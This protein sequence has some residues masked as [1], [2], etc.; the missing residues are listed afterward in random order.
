MNEQPQNNMRIIMI[1][2]T[3][4]SVNATIGL[5]A[6]GYCVVFGIKPDQVLLTAYISIITG[7]LGIIG[8]MLTKTSP[9]ETTKA[10]IPPLFPPT[11]PTPVQ[12]VNEPADPV[13]TKEEPHE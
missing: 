10:I 8:G 2:V 7:L 13:P 1:V 9:T 3:T 12:V 5:S 4:L 6:L 11:A